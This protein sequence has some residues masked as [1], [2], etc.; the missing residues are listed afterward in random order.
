MRATGP[1]QQDLGA[2]PWPASPGIFLC[3]HPVRLRPFTHPA[4]PA[5]GYFG[6][7]CMPCT[8]HLPASMQLLLLK[9]LHST[10]RAFQAM[11]LPQGLQKTQCGSSYG[12]SCGLDGWPWWALLDGG[13]GAWRVCRIPR[14]SLGGMPALFG[15]WPLLG[16]TGTTRKLCLP[17]EPEAL[18]GL[19]GGECSDTWPA[20][21][22]VRILEMESSSEEQGASWGLLRCADA[23]CMWPRRM[24]SCRC[25]CNLWL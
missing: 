7:S 16:R 21:F 24:L 12:G 4:S 15:R 3:L 2:K 1:R 6:V 5:R 14:E 17:E 19:V 22:W 23:A 20:L 9:V 10:Q 18:S 25:G 13:R 11:L 8:P